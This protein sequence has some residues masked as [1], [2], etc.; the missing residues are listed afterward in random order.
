MSQFLRRF[1]RN[2][3]MK[4]TSVSERRIR[5]KETDIG[6]NWTR[7]CRT[8][9]CLMVGR[10]HSYRSLPEYGFQYADDNRSDQS[11]S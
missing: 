9:R 4:L 1:W 8:E 3:L 11:V 10:W 2:V 6:R 5:V 7:F